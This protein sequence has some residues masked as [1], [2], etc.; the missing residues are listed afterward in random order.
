MAVTQT[1][2]DINEG[3]HPIKVLADLKFDDG[4]KVEDFGLYLSFRIYKPAKAKEVNSEDIELSRETFSLGS[5]IVSNVTGLISSVHK[6]GE[7]A[8]LS[9]TTLG[10]GKIYH[11]PMIDFGTR[12]LAEAAE[13]PVNLIFPNSREVKFYLFKSGRSFHGYFNQLLSHDEW[14][15]Y[16]GRLLL[17]NVPFRNEVVDSRWVG[18]SLNKGYSGLRWTANT[19]GYPVSP[20]EPT[21]DPTSVYEDELIADVIPEAESIWSL[22]LS[23]RKLWK[24]INTL[25]Y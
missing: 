15:K 4:Q 14:V 22:L 20:A 12:N 19:I 13:I 5:D 3:R 11:I 18:H 6:D 25:S 24:R 1:L 17:L 21:V 9:K 10:S 16:M 23:P 8:L 7:M 2:I